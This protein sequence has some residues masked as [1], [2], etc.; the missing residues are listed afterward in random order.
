[1]GAARYVWKMLSSWVK[2]SHSA[3]WPEVKLDIIKRHEK[4]EGTSSIAPALNLV[5][6]M[7]FTVLKNT[8]QI[9]KAT[10]GAMNIAKRR[11]E[12]IFDE[13]EC[14]LTVW[15]NNL[16][17]CQLTFFKQK[18]KPFLKVWRLREFEVKVTDFNSSRGWL[19]HFCNRA[20]LH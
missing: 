12:A 10:E 18:P 5:P 1:M 15:I 13:I 3:A 16:S 14:M 17:P 20:G 11:R 7:V 6:S 19:Y 9:K 4:R 2:C 8:E